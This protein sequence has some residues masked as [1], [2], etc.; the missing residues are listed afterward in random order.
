M[1]GMLGQ[2]EAYRALAGVGYHSLLCTKDQDKIGSVGCLF[3]CVVEP[4][5]LSLKLNNPSQ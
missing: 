1:W 5:L 4:G 2:Q 3:G